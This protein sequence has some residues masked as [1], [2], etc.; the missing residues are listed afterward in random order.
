MPVKRAA[1]KPPR[2]AKPRDPAAIAAEVRAILAPA[3]PGLGIAVHTH[4]FLDRIEHFAATLAIWGAKVNLTANPRDPAEIA[5]H[6][7]DSLI[8]FALAVESKA[9][10][11]RPVSERETRILDIGS[12]AGFPGLVI[13]AAIDARVTLAEARRKRATFL[14]DA[15]VEMGLRNVRVAAG[16]AGE[17]DGGFDL[18]TARAVG[19]EREL[20]HDAALAL[21]PGGIF[22]LYASAAQK[23]ALSA[24]EGHDTRAAEAAGFEPGPII[25]YEVHHGRENVPRAAI[26]WIRR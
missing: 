18:V 25:P 26:F 20:F 15:A 8:P 7:F 23:H 2:P 5:F 4:L 3:I 17:I 21:H 22:M 10:R 16:R 24:A 12:G 14:E 1:K 19:H 13:A 6:V 11:L 9:I